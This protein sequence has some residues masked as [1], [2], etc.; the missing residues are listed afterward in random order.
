[1][2]EG[3]Q[4]CLV[5]YDMSNCNTSNLKKVDKFFESQSKYLKSKNYPSS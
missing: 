4:P 5:Y 2:L 1:M 3:N